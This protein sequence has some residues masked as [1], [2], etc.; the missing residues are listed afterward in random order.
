M[1]VTRTSWRG[2]GGRWVAKTSAR[3]VGAFKEVYEERRGKSGRVRD[4]LQRETKKTVVKITVP[5][6]IERE[7]RWQG[8]IARAIDKTN[9]TT[10]KNPKR[11]HVVVKALD[12]RDKAHRFQVSY[13]LK[14]TDQERTNRL[15]SGFLVS[16]VL[17]ALR[18]H[19]Y[20]TQY[21]LDQVD[22][23][24]KRPQVLYGPTGKI[25][26]R[27]DGKPRTMNA[28][29]YSAGLKELHRVGITITIKR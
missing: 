16:M 7:G 20:R 28:R 5:G 23:T 11:L 17:S 15:R 10:T 22:W 24:R 18:S 13:V 4:V 9:A 19:G 1:T 29:R 21:R 3:E 8:M 27:K 14:G 6:E 26:R 12:T 25:L 2:P